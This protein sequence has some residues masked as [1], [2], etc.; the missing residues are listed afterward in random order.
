MSSVRRPAEFD[1]RH[2]RSFLA[3]AEHGSIRRAATALG[4][5][6]STVSRQIRSLEENTGVSLFER[7]GS[8]VRPTSAGSRLAERLRD[9]LANFERAFQHAQRAGSA[10]EGEL[11][12]GFYTSLASGRL[13]SLLGA[14]RTAWPGVCC[15]FTEATPTEQLSGLR[16]RSLDAAFLILTE[17]MQ[18]FQSIPLWT[19]RVYVAL[20]DNH[21][22]ATSD[23]LT[24]ERI[25]YEPFIV[26]RWANGSMI[27]YKLAERK[28]ADGIALNITQHDVSRESLLGL[29]ASG[30]GLT[31]VSEAATGLSVPGLVYRPIDDPDATVT[32]RLAWMPDNDNPALRRFISFAKSSALQE[33]SSAFQAE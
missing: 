19:E 9:A 20:P 15:Q 12:I 6:S 14:Y 30:Q 17:A 31:L 1:F 10:E 18:D 32:V 16:R 27:W 11:S 21:V 8:G 25:R 22:L 4:T 26:R 33:A 7:H 28:I 5:Q 2:I 24:W 13:R 23:V 3:V 29:V